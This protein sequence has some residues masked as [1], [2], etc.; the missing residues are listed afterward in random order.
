ML[1]DGDKMS[2][3]SVSKQCSLLGEELDEACTTYGAKGGR[4]A[5]AGGIRNISAS[6]LKCFEMQLRSQHRT[7]ITERLDGLIQRLYLHNRLGFQA[8]YVP[9]KAQ[10]LQIQPA[11]FEPI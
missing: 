6:G 8:T 7:R 1:S 10:M 2:A 11:L 5:G 3:R 9:S 4:F